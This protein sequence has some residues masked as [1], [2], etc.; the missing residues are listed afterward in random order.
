MN[1][2]NSLF[3]QAYDLAGFRIHA[4]LQWHS[5]V[6]DDACAPHAIFFS[7]FSRWGGGGGGGGDAGAEGMLLRGSYSDCSRDSFEMPLVLNR[8]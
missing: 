8:E 5:Q 7:F 1:V 6:I 3:Y 4:D 2:I